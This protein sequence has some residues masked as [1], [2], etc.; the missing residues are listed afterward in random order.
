MV[1][2]RSWEVQFD[3]RT[4]LIFTLIFIRKFG[5]PGRLHIEAIQRD[6]IQT[7]PLADKKVTTV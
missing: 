4:R 5:V 3:L 7:S 2:F 6:R 1:R